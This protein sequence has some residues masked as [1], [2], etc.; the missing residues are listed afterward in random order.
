MKQN[1]WNSNWITENYSYLNNVV[2]EVSQLT[3]G[4]QNSQAN[5]DIKSR[6]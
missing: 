4:I 5:E 3:D 2:Y 1:E 6:W